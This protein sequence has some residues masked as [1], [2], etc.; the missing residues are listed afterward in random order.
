MPEDTKRI[1][2]LL[3]DLDSDAFAEREAASR[4]LIR[5][6]YRVGPLLRK[7]L[8]N[9]PTLEVRRRLEAILVEPNRPSIEA[10]R[11]LRAIAVLERIGTPEAQRIL[12]KLAGGADAPET[13]EAQAALQRLNRRDASANGRTSP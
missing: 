5:L 4:E 8:R 11:T 13:R 12:E 2:Q 10:L 7:A 1:E 6:R 9:K 3:A